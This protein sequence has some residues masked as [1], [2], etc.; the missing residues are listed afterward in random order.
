M[1]KKA[2]GLSNAEARILVIGLDNSGKTTLINHIKPQK[3]IATFEVTPTVGYQVETFTKHNLNFTILD[4]SGSSTYR[5][6]WEQYY[7]D[8]SAIIFV[9]DSTDK[10]RMCI[11]R[12]ELDELL[13]NPL[14]KSR[15]LPICFFANKMDVPGSLTP[16]DCMRGMGLE[17]IDNKPWH[18]T[19]SNA[20][21]G[22]GVDEGVMWL[23]EKLMENSEKLDGG[24]SKYGH[25]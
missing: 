12:D 14:I 10:V 8:V 19:S 16:V 11:A 20:L 21:T 13:N 17:K 9:L 24:E 6:L 5:S 3:A 1:L 25:K 23:A 7:N 22:A 4:M 15:S 18:I 2:L